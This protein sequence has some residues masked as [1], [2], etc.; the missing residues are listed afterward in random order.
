[1]LQSCFEKLPSLS[2][3]PSYSR[4]VQIPRIVRT[5]GLIPKGARSHQSMERLQE[6][7]GRRF[8]HATFKSELQ[9]KAVLAVYE[10]EL[11]VRAAG[12]DSLVTRL[13]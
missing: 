2:L 9:R 1:M 13:Q 11:A 12:R 5:W 10:G 8:G 6:E 4:Y 3:W 7:L